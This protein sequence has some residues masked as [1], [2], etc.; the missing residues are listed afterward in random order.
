MLD[1]KEDF[2]PGAPQNLNTLGEK[3]SAQNYFSFVVFRSVAG[4]SV[5]TPGLT[6]PLVYVNGSM[7]IRS[8]CSHDLKQ[9]RCWSCDFWKWMISASLRF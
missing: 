6:E 8:R 1:E 4:K 7:E 9:R 3:A 2:P 5:V